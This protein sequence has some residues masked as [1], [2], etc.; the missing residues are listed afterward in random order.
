MVYNEESLP[1]VCNTNFYPYS[2]LSTRGSSLLWLL[3]TESERTYSV[4]SHPAESLT[5]MSGH[6]MLLECFINS[7]NGE[8]V[9]WM[10]QGIVIILSF[11]RASLHTDVYHHSLCRVW[12]RSCEKVVAMIA[13]FPNCRSYWCLAYSYWIKRGCH[14]CTEPVYQL[15]ELPT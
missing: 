9:T 13:L 14:H 1:L 15:E 8:S 12:I 4:L 3:F 11:Y 7:A 2:F 10:L 6:V 5:V